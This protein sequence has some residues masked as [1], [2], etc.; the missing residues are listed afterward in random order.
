HHELPL[1]RSGDADA[2]H[3][4]A[5]AGVAARSDSRDASGAGGDADGHRL[6]RRSG[7]A[8]ESVERPPARSGARAVRHRGQLFGEVRR[9]ADAS[10]DRDV[11]ANPSLLITHAELLTCRI[12]VLDASNGL[13]ISDGRAQRA[14]IDSTYASFS[15]A[16]VRIVDPFT[17]KE[18]DMP[19]SGFV[20]G[21]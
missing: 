11:A 4:H 17:G 8:A 5:Q 18:A 2:A 19:P 10:Y 12:A 1:F 6:S 7:S 3:A 13:T 21:I 14:K 16:W 9:S 15:Y 20:A